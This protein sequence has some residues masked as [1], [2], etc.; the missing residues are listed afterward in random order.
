MSAIEIKRERHTIVRT[1]NEVRV[2]G[3]LLINLLQ[4]ADMD[5]PDDADVVVDAY[6]RG[7]NDIDQDRPIVVRWVTEEHS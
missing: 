6:E 5:V 2:S 4:L 1:Q 7:E 3:R